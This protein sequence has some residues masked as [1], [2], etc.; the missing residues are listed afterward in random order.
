VSPTTGVTRAT[1][2]IE[3]ASLL[4]GAISISTI[5]TTCL[6]GPEGL[7]G[8]SRVGTINGQPIGTGSGSITIPLV[9]TVYYNQTVTTPAGELFQYA[10]RVRT[11]LGQE[12]V[13]AGCRVG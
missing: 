4:G 8:S 5:E 13:L 3:G 1:A 2:S 11:L 6:A 10:I 7:T 12:I 9:A